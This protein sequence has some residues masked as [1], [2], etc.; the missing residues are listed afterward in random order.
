MQRAVLKGFVLLSCLVV[1]P[2]QGIMDPHTFAA[3]L[4]TF[5]CGPKVKQAH[6]GV[7]GGAKSDAPH[8]LRV[9]QSLSFLSGAAQVSRGP[10]KA[11]Q[12]VIPDAEVGTLDL[13]Y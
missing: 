8:H 2:I 7:G 4:E 12:G 10:A 1:R 13:S 11:K 6:P 5:L 3:H 9:A